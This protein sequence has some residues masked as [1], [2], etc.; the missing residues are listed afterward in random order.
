MREDN[1]SREGGFF[2]SHFLEYGAKT[3]NLLYDTP[4]ESSL[5]EKEEQRKESAPIQISNIFN[6]RYLIRE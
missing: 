6:F 3:R 2:E 4:F 1:K 5:S